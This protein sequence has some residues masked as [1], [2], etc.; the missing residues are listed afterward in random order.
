MGNNYMRVKNPD[1]LLGGDIVVIPKDAECYGLSLTTYSRIGLHNGGTC[2]S[3]NRSRDVKEFFVNR[4]DR[5]QVFEVMDP[6]PTPVLPSPEDM[7][8]AA[9]LSNGVGTRPDYPVTD[10]CVI[11]PLNVRFESEFTGPG[12]LGQ[13][14]S[15]LGSAVEKARKLIVDSRVEMRFVNRNDGGEMVAADKLASSVPNRIEIPGKEPRN[16]RPI[17]ELSVYGWQIGMYK[18]ETDA[19]IAGPKVVDA[20]FVDSLLRGACYNSLRFVV[21]GRFVKEMCAR[22]AYV[23]RP[24]GPGISEALAGEVARRIFAEFAGGFEDRVDRLM[25]VRTKLSAAKALMECAAKRFNGLASKYAKSRD[26]A[27]ASFVECTTEKSK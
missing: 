25:E 17:P 23:M 12:R 16:V 19:G 14:C 22:G 9:L 26:A 6:R 21:S 11:V 27:I 8:R 24:E 15:N 18:E 2:R 5:T 1:R 10:S 7:R 3:E 13:W 4:R 20:A